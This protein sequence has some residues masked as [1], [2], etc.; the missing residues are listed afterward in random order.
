M[1]NEHFKKISRKPENIYFHLMTTFY[2]FALKIETICAKRAE[3]RK[4]NVCVCFIYLFSDKKACNVKKDNSKC[5]KFTIK[6]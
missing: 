5:T 6:C 3:S 2:N 1:K 4:A